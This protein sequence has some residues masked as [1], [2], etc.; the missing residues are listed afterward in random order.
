MLC[1]C[2]S[3]FTQMYAVAFMIKSSIIKRNVEYKVKK[4]M[5]SNI[6]LQQSCQVL[7]ARLENTFKVSNKQQ[8][9]QK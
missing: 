5:V 4:L 6:L 7:Y 1:I 3:H 8:R 2:I 9:K